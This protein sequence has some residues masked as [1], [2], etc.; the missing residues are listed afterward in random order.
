M[1]VCVRR[2]VPAVRIETVGLDRD[3]FLVSVPNAAG[4]VNALT[5]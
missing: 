2:S 1:F 5:G 3:A 4:V